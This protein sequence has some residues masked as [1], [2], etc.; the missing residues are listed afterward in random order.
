MIVGER[1]ERGKVGIF[2]KDSEDAKG[3]GAE[4]EEEEEEEER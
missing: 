3:K 2:V 4:D 1:R